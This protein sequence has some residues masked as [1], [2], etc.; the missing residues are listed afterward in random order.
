MRDTYGSVTELQRHRR[1]GI[2]YDIEIRLGRNPAAA[3]IAPHGGRIEP[4]TSE[5][6][7]AV[8]G[9]E[10]G[11]YSFKGLIP[12]SFSILHVTSHHFDEELCLSFL[13]SHDRVVAVHGLRDGDDVT[14][15]GGRDWELREAV[16]ASL[17]AS[18]FA[19]HT[20]ESGAYSAMDPANICNRGRAGRGV[21]L[22]LPKALRDHLRGNPTDLGRY[23]LAVQSAMK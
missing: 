22:E 15:V 4:T 21:Q 10:F 3:A 18:G 20:A 16:T 1:R 9:D 7:A 11:Y 6:A 8:A 23:A 14:I 19:T 12:D 5:L 2:D 13:A 17:N